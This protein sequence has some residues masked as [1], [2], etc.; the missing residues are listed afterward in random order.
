MRLRREEVEEK[1]TKSGNNDVGQ[2]SNQF[3]TGLLTTTKTKMMMM[4]LRL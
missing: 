4:I 1:S 3:Q 2:T